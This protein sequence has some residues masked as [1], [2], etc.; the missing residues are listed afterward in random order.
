MRTG[1]LS[2]RIWTLAAV[3]ILADTVW[4]QAQ[5]TSETYLNQQRQVEEQIRSELDKQLPVEQKVLVDWGGWLSDNFFLFDDGIESSRTLRRY[6][7]R[8]WG[9][10]NADEGIHQGYVRMRMGLNDFNHGDSY[11]DNEDDIE[12]PNLDRG[13][14][15]LD[16]TK[17]LQ[18]YE[19]LDLPFGLATT[20]GR[21]YVLWG[22]GYA[23]SLPLDAVQVTSNI[24][25]LEIDG[26]FGRTVHSWDNLDTS[27]PHF[28][29][30][31]RYFYGVQFAY[32][33]F[34]KHKPFLYYVWQ[35]DRQDDGNPLVFLQQWQYDSEYLGI[36]SAGQLGS[37]WRYSGELVYEQ[38]R[39]YGERQFRHRNK[40][41][42]YGWDTQLEYFHPGKTH[43]RVIFE[44]MFASGDPDRLLSPSNAVGGNEA[45]TKDT[46]FN[47]FGYRDTG[48]ALAADLSNIHIWRTGA[49][50][51]PFENQ[52][53]EWL[54]KLEMGT[55]WF[56]YHKHHRD[57]AIS[58][59]LA[60]QQSGYLGWETDYYINWRFTSDLAW[61]IRYGAFF[62]G[63]AFSDQTTRTFLLTGITWNF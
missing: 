21:D 35:R 2:R 40:I 50:F 42:A 54:K 32:K 33:G 10:L 14:Y 25:D 46:G 59:A 43:P 38:G 16:W 39:S 15:R 53:T 63:G 13:W 56:L 48:I 51:F 36:G 41:C 17:F 28:W 23:L 11:D 55:D 6:D 34:E 44:Y 9:S 3:I 27:R 29:D 24:G 31:W 19:S 18:K 45:F 52:K 5:A 61:T 49:S 37:N 62:P 58:D 12:G 20:V 1:Q 22:T 7:F 57:A 8:L 60:D 30:S 26:L 47:A 4:L